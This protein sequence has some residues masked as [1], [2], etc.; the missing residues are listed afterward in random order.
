MEWNRQ[1]K[2]T[3]MCATCNFTDRKSFWTIILDTYF[4]SLLCYVFFLLFFFFHIVYKIIGVVDDWINILIYEWLISGKYIRLVIVKL[5]FFFSLY[6]KIDT[7]IE[8][9][10][11]SYIEFWN[12]TRYCIYVLLRCQGHIIMFVDT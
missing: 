6:F 4:V 11:S 5:L 7:S 2:T 12:W 9:I 10:L 3:T 8:T 1:I